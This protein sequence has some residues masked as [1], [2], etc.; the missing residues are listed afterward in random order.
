MN[1]GW[2]VVATCKVQS[3][4]NYAPKVHQSYELSADSCFEI[5]GRGERLVQLWFWTQPSPPPAVA[6]ARPWLLRSAVRLLLV[7]GCRDVFRDLL[8]RVRAG[9][10]LVQILHVIEAFNNALCCQTGLRVM[11]PALLDGGA[12]HLDA[13]WGSQRAA[14]PSCARLGHAC[15]GAYMCVTCVCACFLSSDSVQ[16][17]VVAHLH[18]W[19][20]SNAGWQ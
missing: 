16:L 12:H 1:F 11:V 7:H 10:D 8:L 5:H 13:L 14:L 20:W 15:A 19:T 18:R 6:E 3:V 9:R 4:F 2:Q 17:S